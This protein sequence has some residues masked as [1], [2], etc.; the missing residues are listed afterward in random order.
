VKLFIAVETTICTVSVTKRCVS[1]VVCRF[2]YLWYCK[3]SL[4]LLP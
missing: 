4:K 1:F 2:A 3:F